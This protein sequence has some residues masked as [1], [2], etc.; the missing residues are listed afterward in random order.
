ME[1]PGYAKVLSDRKDLME[2]FQL[3][4]T[5]S[6][7]NTFPGTKLP[8]MRLSYYPL[9]ILPV[10][11]VMKPSA[12]NF[13]AKNGFG[14]GVQ[15]VAFVS[16]CK[17]AGASKRLAYL[18]ELMSLIDVHSY[19]NCL[20]NREEPAYRFDPRWPNQRRARKVKT[21]SNYKFYLAFENLQV[22]DYVSEKV[23][24][25]LFAGSV[26][27]YR[28]AKEIAKFM[29]SPDSY[30]DANA[31]SPPELAALLKQ[32]ASDESSYQRFF[33][34]KDRPLRPGF[35][36]MAEDSY[37]HPNVLCRLCEYAANRTEA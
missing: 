26:P 16:N 36:S 18:R 25:G 35:T 29:P 22:K 20:K 27:V 9:N 5:Y 23:F 28:G 8:N 3:M 30:V 31:M 37:C 13:T 6:W 12:L 33:A 32:L 19:G 21:V 7:E 34:F 10:S 2:N 15:V 11:E 4:V 17:N 14:T 1:Q 24:E